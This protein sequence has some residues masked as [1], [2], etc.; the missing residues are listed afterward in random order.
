MMCGMGAF[1]L[2]RVLLGLL[3]MFVAVSGAF[4]FFATKFAPLASTP[5]SPGTPLP[6]A[7]WTWL[8]GVF[9][10]RS[11]THGLIEPHLLSLVGH[12]F[13]RTLLL[14]LL[15]L[16]I[17]VVIAVPVGI[18]AA[19]RRGTLLDYGLRIST[20]V[21]WAIPAFVVAILFQE[22]LGRIPGGWGTG[23]FPAV[24]WAGECPNGQGID[25]SNFQC[26]AAG[27]GVTHVGEIIYHLALPA[28]ALALGFIGIHA[29]YL[30]NSML[31][32]LDAPYITVARGK[33]LRERT[34]LLHHALRNA[35]VAFVPQLVSDLGLLFGAALAVDYIFQLGGLGTLFI[36]LLELNV[37]GIPQVDTYALVFALLIGAGVILIVSVLSEIALA[38]LDPRMRTD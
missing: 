36:G 30:R 6:R 35:L 20:Y 17:V 10:G 38:L 9:T 7:Y 11:F 27:H 21:A 32:A 25:P 5:L 18:I 13:W 37:D 29:R 16:V 19:S 34:V 12:A 26:P 3:V 1:V 4:I 28:F 14:L 8:S 31:D 15:T 33:G 23:W 24:G 22:G 2:R